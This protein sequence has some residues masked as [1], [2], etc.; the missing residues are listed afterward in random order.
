MIR[1]AEFYYFLAVINMKINI[2][3]FINIVR[4]LGRSFRSCFK[5]CHGA[6]NF[7]N[8][9]FRM[10]FDF[11]VVQSCCHFLFLLFLICHRLVCFWLF[12]WWYVWMF[13][14]QRNFPVLNHLA[15]DIRSYV[16]KIET[17]PFVRFH[18]L[19]S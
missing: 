17:K 16:S 12:V 15:S 1:Q 11:V 8:A 2:I 10:E 9:V 14:S 5:M 4:R 7:A 6:Q 13:L 3:E 19:T 18:I